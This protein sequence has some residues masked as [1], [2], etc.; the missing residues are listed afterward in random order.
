MGLCLNGPKT[1]YLAYNTVTDPP[2]RTRDS[3]V[4]ERKTD[5][6]Y[7]GSWV[8][9]STKDIAARKA[10]AWRALNDM[11][12]IWKSNMDQSLKKRFFVATVESILLYGCESWALT[13]TMEK[14]LDGTHTRM[15]RSAMN[16][17]WDSFTTNDEVYGQL[18]RIS[19]KIAA[20]RLDLLVTATVIP[21]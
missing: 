19:D 4:L 5:F 14:S 9:E 12:K 21:N 7:L 17:P 11:S 8:D 20:R 15:L 6:K 2:L 1:K 13:V 10:L 3:T 16:I 18:P